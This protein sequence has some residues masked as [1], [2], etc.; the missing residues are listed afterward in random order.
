[1]A[2]RCFVIIISKQNYQIFFKNV[3][4]IKI[5]I[6]LLSSSYENNRFYD[7]KM[8]QISYCYTQY[9]YKKG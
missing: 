8:L 9:Y 2:W 6:L 7:L 5:K 1:M 3:V 4:I